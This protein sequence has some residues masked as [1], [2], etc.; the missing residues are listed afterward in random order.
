MTRERAS[1]VTLVKKKKKNPLAK[2][3]TGIRSLG[4]EDP[5]EKEMATHSSILAWEMLWTGELGESVHNITKMLDMT[6][7]LTTTWLGKLFWS[8]GPPGRG[9]GASR[10]P[11]PHF[12]NRLMGLHRV[13]NR[14][15]GMDNDKYN[16]QL[17][18]RL[19]HILFQHFLSNEGTEHSCWEADN[20][21]SRTFQSP[22]WI[23]PAYFPKVFSKHHFISSAPWLDEKTRTSFSFSTQG[24]RCLMTCS[25][26][27]QF[28]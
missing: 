6:Q 13:G 5:L 24:N 4:Q 28:L 7:Q 16:W 20:K 27:P 2:Q 17:K 12:R 9:I 25:R 3:E 22:L 10:S 21:Y 18:L 19:Q 8:H 26:F 23:F 14:P 1:L 11:G 15:V